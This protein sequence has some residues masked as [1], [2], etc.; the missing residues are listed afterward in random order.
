[1][2]WTGERMI[3]QL[4]MGAGAAEHL[5]RYVFAS[6]FC[7]GKTVLDIASGEGYGTNLLASVAAHVYGVDIDN[8]AV[9]E[10]SLKYK[11]NSIQF[12]QGGVTSIPLPQE[13]VDAIVSF[14]TIEH[15]REHEAMMSEFKRVLR[16]DGLLIISTPAKEFYNK[17]NKFHLK[18]LTSSEFYE[19][20]GKFFKNVHFYHQKHID[21]SFIYSVDEKINFPIQEFAGDFTHW[22]II[23]QNSYTYNVAVCTNADAGISITKSSFFKSEHFTKSYYDFELDRLTK[24][25]INTYEKSSSYK[26][27]KVLLSPFIFL[28]KMIARK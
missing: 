6:S 1:M 22:D 26:V 11:K 13:C 4:R 27:G 10:A 5:H 8:N 25:I 7:K 24:K 12:L 17:E 21:S 2:E 28:K 15:L 14:E 9:N 3:T 19:L 18:E 23:K 20:L 16:K